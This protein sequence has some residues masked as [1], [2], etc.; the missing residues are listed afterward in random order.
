MSD[1]VVPIR[2]LLSL[3]NFMCILGFMLLLVRHIQVLLFPT[4]V[5]H[6]ILMENNPSIRHPKSVYLHKLSGGKKRT[7]QLPILFE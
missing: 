2:T 1:V 3:A 7:H 5:D 6:I 4:S